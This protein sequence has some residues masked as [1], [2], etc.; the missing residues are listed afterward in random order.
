[1]KGRWGEDV[2]SYHNFKVNRRY[3]KLKGKALDRF[4]NR[5]DFLRNYG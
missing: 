1:M 3:W 2:S 5:T 4:L